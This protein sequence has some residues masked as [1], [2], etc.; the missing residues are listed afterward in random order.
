MTDFNVIGNIKRMWIKIA[1]MDE[2]SFDK[3]TQI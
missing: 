2:D 1:Y 3:Q